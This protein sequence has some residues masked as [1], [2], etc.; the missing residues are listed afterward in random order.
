MRLS[1]PL[2]L[3]QSGRLEL[4]AGRRSVVARFAEPVAILSD[5]SCGGGWWPAGAAIVN[6]QMTARAIRSQA[7]L[8]AYR[9]QLL[10]RLELPADA[11]LQLTAAKV[12]AGGLQVEWL[13]GPPAA[14]RLVACA[15]AGV[16]DNAVW[17][18]DPA[19]YRE[20]EAGQFDPLTS[21]PAAAGWDIGTINVQ[22]FIDAQLDFAAALHLFTL[23]AECKTD[24]LRCR[25]VPSCYSR[26]PATGTGTD[27]LT[28]VW[29]PAAAR[30]FTVAS[31][32]SE[33]GQRVALCVRAALGEVLD[34]A[35]NQSPSQSPNQAPKQAPDQ[36]IV[37]STAHA[38]QGAISTDRSPI[39]GTANAAAPAVTTAAATSDAD[40]GADAAA[41]DAAT[42]A[43]TSTSTATTTTTVTT[44][45]RA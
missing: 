28:L 11:C 44:G 5:S 39:I 24:E 21:R 10:T 43:G 33:F 19:G 17:A 36:A 34:N 18:G 32:H 8:A 7:E 15:S 41:T 38:A 13:A 23:V 30:R 20:G 42:L 6:H 9:D 3:F 26:Q 29:N 27:S 22:L 37:S 2:P 14:V 35:L 1:R 25:Q 4:A 12:A 16:S 40:S 45:E 31:T